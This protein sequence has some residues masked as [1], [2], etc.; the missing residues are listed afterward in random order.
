MIDTSLKEMVVFRCPLSAQIFSLHFD[1]LT[2]GI[3]LQMA[4]LDTLIGTLMEILVIL[5]S[6]MSYFDAL[7]VALAILFTCEHVYN[8]S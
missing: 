7:Q 1:T 4:I 3:S 2:L 8:F 6:F 5:P